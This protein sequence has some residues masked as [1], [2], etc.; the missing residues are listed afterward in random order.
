MVVGDDGKPVAAIVSAIRDTLPAV[1]GRAKAAEDGAFMIP[2][3]TAGVYTICA[4]VEDLGYL[5]P[6]IWSAHPLTVQVGEGDAATDARV[7]MKKAVPLQVRLDDPGKVLGQT[8]SGKQSGPKVLMGV[9]TPRR[10]FQPLQMR[11]TDAKGRDYQLLVPA[12]EAAASLY[13]VARGA[14]IVDQAGAEVEPNGKHMQ[15]VRSKGQEPQVVSLTIKDS[16]TP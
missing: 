8:I 13:V 11:S 15:L 14:T 1:G 10:L 16:K 12:D 7:V 4:A 6:C 3:L 9:F 5:D 2:G